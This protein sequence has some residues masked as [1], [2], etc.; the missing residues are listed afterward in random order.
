[1]QTVTSKDGTSI[2]F[3][4]LGQG[5]AVI[6][7]SGGSVDRSSNA[8]L[9]ELLAPH[10]T[11][12]NYDR[13]GRGPSGDTPPYAVERE[14]EDIEA[15][16]DAAGGTAYLYGSSSGAA[17]ALEAARTLPGKITKLALWEVP[18]IP[19]G[20]PRPPADTAQTFTRLVAEGRRGDAAEFF[21]AK[22]VGLP[23]EF[24]AQARQAPWWPNQEALAHTL[25]YDA[26]IMGDYRLPADRAAQVTIPTLVLDGSAS[27]PFMHETAVTLASV[28]PNAQQRTLE[29]QTHDVSAEALAS[30]LTA[31]FAS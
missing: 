27:F 17:L 6:L 26:T 24:V 22:V 30:A 5:P 10:F 16:A 19:E 31:F 12:Y 8:A 13:R 9:A 14:I 23:P 25:A 20:Y 11:V 7:V 15:V 18:Y 28:L 4:R 3:D 21:M 1:M 2:A 29:R